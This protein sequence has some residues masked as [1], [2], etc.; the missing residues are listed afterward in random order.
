[1]RSREFQGG[2]IIRA[3]QIIGGHLSSYQV[4]ESLSG[5]IKSWDAE[6]VD[7]NAASASAL[8]LPLNVNTVGP[9]YNVIGHH[10]H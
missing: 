6:A 4:G 1:M 3:G 7:C 2:T 9:R 8:P 5:C 10:G